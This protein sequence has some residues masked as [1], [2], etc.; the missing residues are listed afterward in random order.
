MLMYIGKEWG[1]G[2][3]ESNND[4]R[5]RQRGRASDKER[6]RERERHKQRER[7]KEAKG[8]EGQEGRSPNTCSLRGH[9]TRV[10]TDLIGGKGD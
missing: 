8:E 9:R 5:N 2:W 4:D 10:V 6:E 3:R 1:W 7:G